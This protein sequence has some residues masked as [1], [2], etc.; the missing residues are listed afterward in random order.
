MDH[1]LKTSSVHWIEYC[2]WLHDLYM[3]VLEGS[4]ACEHVC[5]I[6][7]DCRYDCVIAQPCVVIHLLR[8]LI[9]P[10]W[11]WL[12]YSLISNTFHDQ[13]WEHLHQNV[14][15]LWMIFATSQHW[16]CHHLVHYQIHCLRRFMMPYNIS[17]TEWV[18]WGLMLISRIG[19][20]FDIFRSH[21]PVPIIMP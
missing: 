6:V 21:S 2:V 10:P 15:V 19:F 9:G 12:N 20:W 1:I 5:Q 13:Y 17:M 7:P 8:L 4:S 14:C 3:F 16:T 18:K 11:I